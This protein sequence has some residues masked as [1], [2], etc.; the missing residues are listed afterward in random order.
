MVLFT[1]PNSQNYENNAQFCRHILARAGKHQQEME[2]LV[3]SAY[4]NQIMSYNKINSLIKAVEDNNK[5]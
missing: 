3:V 4:R 5:K 1:T 2:S